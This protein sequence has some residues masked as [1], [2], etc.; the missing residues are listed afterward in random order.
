MDTARVRNWPSIT[1]NDV[2]VSSGQIMTC[3]PDSD[4]RSAHV[5]AP[6]SGTCS[7]QKGKPATCVAY[8]KCSPFMLM[9]DNLIKPLPNVKSVY[10]DDD[11]CISSPSRRSRSSCRRSTSAGWTLMTGA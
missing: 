1:S 9:L 4:T 5:T 6:D 8:N 7:L 11:C 2:C 3:C 10:C